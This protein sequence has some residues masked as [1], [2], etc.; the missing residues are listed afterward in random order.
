MARL[1]EALGVSSYAELGRLI[2]LTTS[3]YANRKRADSIPY[4]TI[5]PLAK[6]HKV[7]IDW[8]IFGESHAPANVETDRIPAEIDPNLLAQVFIALQKAFH[9]DLSQDDVVEL[10]R[11]ASL[12]GVI[13]NRVVY[14][15]SES[16]RNALLKHEANEMAYFLKVMQDSERRAE[17]SPIP[18]GKKQR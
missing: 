11:L 4:E 13:Y 3:A 5:I 16:V 2:G 12:A 1:K 15:E 18:P 6:A 17:A 7:S 9:P 10:G 14:S 8:L